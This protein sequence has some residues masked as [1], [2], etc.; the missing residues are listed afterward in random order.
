MSPQVHWVSG[1]V[2]RFGVRSSEGFCSSVFSLSVNPK[3]S[4][5]YLAA[6]SV[7]G[8]FKVSLL[9]SGKW[10]IGFTAAHG[11]DRSSATRTPPSLKAS[12]ERIVDRW[13][14]PSEMEPG[15]TKAFAVLIASAG[16]TLPPTDPPSDL[17]E[18]NWYPKPE[19]KRLVEFQVFLSAPALAIGG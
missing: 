17:A 9:S 8:D 11:E 16:V 2:I 12:H 7:A 1:R 14:R 15:L 5:V 4:D 13:P 10:Q 19:A 3:A 18:V 6:R